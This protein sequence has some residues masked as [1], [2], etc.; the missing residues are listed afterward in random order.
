MATSKKGVNEAESY[1][2]LLKLGVIG[3]F[4]HV[5]PEHLH[6]Y[7]DEFDF[8]WSNR[9]M[10]DTRRDMAI[11]QIEGKRLMYKEPKAN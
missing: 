11:K 2:S 8:R 3:A 1:F 7:C 4:H 6:R 5:S 10:M 9:K